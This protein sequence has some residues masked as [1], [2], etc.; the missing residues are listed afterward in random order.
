ML[1]F[2]AY[3]HLRPAMHTLS[4]STGLGFAHFGELSGVGKGQRV[5]TACK[6]FKKCRLRLII[7]TTFNAHSF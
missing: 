6:C 5:S 1:T 2:F 3:P 4:I 7:T